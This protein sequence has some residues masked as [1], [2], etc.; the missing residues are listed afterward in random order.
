MNQSSPQLGIR[1]LFIF[2][3]VFG[4]AFA[5]SG[6]LVAL[7][8][9]AAGGTCGP[10]SSSETPIVAFFDPVTIGAGPEP[11]VTNLAS[12]EDWQAF[13][14]DCQTSTD[15]RVIAAGVILVV[16]V[17]VAIVGPPLVR[18]RVGRPAAPLTPY[19]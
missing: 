10:G 19:A 14:D 1:L 15:N 12:R 9:P 18:R 3:G 7:P 2:L 8:P 11:A 6:V 16:S 5:I 13:V 17:L 4:A